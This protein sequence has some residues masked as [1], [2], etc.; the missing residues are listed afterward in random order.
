GGKAVRLVDGDTT[1]PGDTLRF[2]VSCA[3][4]QHVAV[5][6]VDGAG[7]ISAYHP[8]G[9]RAERVEPGQH[10]VLDGAI[11]LDDVLGRETLHAVFCS[12]AVAVDELRAALERD[13]DAPHFADGCTSARMVLEKR[14]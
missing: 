2:E 8:T 14:R 7:T 9:P 4:P 10:V 6:S 11:E 12:E 13:R 3:T 1:H 5:L